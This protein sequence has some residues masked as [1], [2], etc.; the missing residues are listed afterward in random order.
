MN[1]YVAKLDALR[2]IAPDGSEYWTARDLQKP[3]GYEDW[4]NFTNA[5]EKAKSSCESAGSQS[6]HHFVGFTNMVEIGSGAQRPTD[7]WFLSR[8]ACYL[9]AM[10]GEPSKKEVALAQTYFTVQTRRQEIDD[11]LGADEHRRLLRERVRDGN[12]KLAKAAKQANVQK[13]AVF[14]DAGLKGLY[15][16]LGVA[17]LKQRKG[18]PPSDDLLDCVDRVELAMHDFKNTQAEAKILR[19][20]IQTEALAIQVHR[21]VA[22]GVREAVRKNGGPLPEDLPA[23]ENIKQIEKRR[24]L[25]GR[26]TSIQGF[27]DGKA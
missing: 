7:D 4:R 19:E 23:V 22:E 26:Q 10:N 2:R 16:G 9:I 21:K 27:L 12:K 14:N 17:E 11:Q 6:V 18:I 25:Q 3:L 15:S 1:D 24:R 13:F 20:S 5:I 8:Y